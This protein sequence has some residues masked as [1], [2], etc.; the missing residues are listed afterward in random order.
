MRSVRRSLCAAMLT[1]QAVV[2]GLTALVM[3][4]VGGVPVGTALSVALGL[5]GVCLLAA[6]TLRTPFG[7]WLGWAVQVGSL[8]LGVLVPIMFFLGAVFAAL[9]TGAYFL[10]AKIDREKAERVEIEQQWRADHAG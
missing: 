5:A 8:A 2:L 1:L 9:W 6:S 10:G 7:L 3:I 4:G